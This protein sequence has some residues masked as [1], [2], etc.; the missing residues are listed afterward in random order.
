MELH[1]RRLVLAPFIA[2]LLLLSSTAG[3]E[4]ATILVNTTIDDPEDGACSLNEAQST[5]QRR[6]D[7]GGCTHAGEFAGAGD[8]IVIE[9][10]STCVTTE[11]ALCNGDFGGP[12]PASGVTA[13]VPALP[14]NLGVTQAVTV[15]PPVIV[16][17]IGTPPAIAAVSP[18]VTALS[19]EIASLISSIRAAA[20]LG[21]V[22]QV[23]PVAPPVTA[24]PIAAE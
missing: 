18:L 9:T 2:I 23:A 13:I 15:A 20:P 17:P 12:G 14:T 8:V 5:S 6:Q 24:Q 21:F 7:T 10:V 3:L 16:Q 4:A 19:S 1:S 22:F 11:T